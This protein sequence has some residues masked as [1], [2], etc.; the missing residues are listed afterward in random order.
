M[1]MIDACLL[2]NRLGILHGGTIASMG[3]RVLRVVHTE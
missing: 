2:Q 3:M 1:L